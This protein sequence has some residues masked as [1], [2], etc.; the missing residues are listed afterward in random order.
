MTTYSPSSCSGAKGV[1]SR[2]TIY[3]GMS[4]SNYISNNKQKMSQSNNKIPLLEK[5]EAR[6]AMLEFLIFIKRHQGLTSVI[7]KSGVNGKFLLVDKPYDI[8]FSKLIK[9]LIAILG[10]CA[11]EEEFIE[12]LKAMIPQ[13]SKFTD[14]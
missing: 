8:P 12:F 13:M 6:S 14:K 2:A 3:G 9:I 4:L 7:Q 10:F 1:N 11:T 5:G